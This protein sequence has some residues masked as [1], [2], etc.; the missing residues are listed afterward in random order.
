MSGKLIF[1]FLILSTTTFAMDKTSSYYRIDENNMKDKL[2]QTAM[3]QFPNPADTEKSKLPVNSATTF[4]TL[5]KKHI[6]SVYYKSYTET[7]PLA[8]NP[9]AST[10]FGQRFT[11]ATENGLVIGA[12]ALVIGAIRTSADDKYTSEIWLKDSGYCAIFAFGIVM[13]TDKDILQ[14][15]EENI[16]GKH[17]QLKND[18]K[19]EKVGLSIMHTPN[20]KIIPCMG[21][22]AR[23]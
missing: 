5:D 10:T 12:F 16:T 3:E 4:I 18:I 19:F 1:L 7:E 13:L 9:N 15:I 23:Y 14:L 20:G 6:S 2:P 22:S 8:P 11:K 21:L 17:T